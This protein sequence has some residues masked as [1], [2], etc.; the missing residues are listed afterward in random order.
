MGP[1]TWPREF[2]RVTWSRLP[3][4]R[5]LVVYSWWWWLVSESSD[6]R[7]PSGLIW[8]SLICY[9]FTACNVFYG[10]TAHGLATD[11]AKKHASAWGR[12]VNYPTHKLNFH[13]CPATAQPWEERRAE[14]Q[15]LPERMRFAI[16][17]IGTAK[18]LNHLSALLLQHTVYHMEPCETNLEEHSQ[19]VQHMRR[20]SCWLQKRR[21]EL[22]GFVRL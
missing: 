11:H 20:S 7:M 18:V 3:N 16:P 14:M 10:L 19:G 2:F 6:C 4:F 22:L 1:R 17:T 15:R 13:S 21:N 9:L 8:S 5:R 12:V